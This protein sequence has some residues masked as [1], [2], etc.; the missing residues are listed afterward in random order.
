MSAVYS[1]QT[2]VFAEKQ[3][4]NFDVDAV[5]ARVAIAMRPASQRGGPVTDDE[6]VRARAFIAAD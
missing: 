5:V 3:R 1:A 2:K 4:Q 6:L